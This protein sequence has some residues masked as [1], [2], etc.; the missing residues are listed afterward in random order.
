MKI[1]FIALTSLLLFT[2]I[3]MKAQFIELPDILQETQDQHEERMRWWNDAKFGMF[4]HWGVYA[5]PGKGEWIMWMDQIPV[6]EY[7]KLAD[8][9]NPDPD[10]MEQWAAVAKEAGMKYMVLTTRHCDGFCLW[11]SKSSWQDFTIMNTPAKFDAVG[12]FVESARKQD[13]RVGFYYSVTDWRFP[14]YFLPGIYR[15]SAEQ[16]KKQGYEQA[17]E[18]LTEYG[19]I[20]IMWWDAGSDDYIALAYEVQGFEIVKRWTNFGGP[21]ERH[22]AGPPLWEGNKLNAMVRELQPNIIINNRIS[23]Q[24]IEWE[25][26]YYTPEGRVGKFDTRRDWET[27]EVLSTGWWGWEPDRSIK[28]LEHVITNLVSIVTGGGNYLLNVGPRPDGYIAPQYVE[29]LREVGRWLDKYGESIYGTRAGPHPNGE[30]GGF[31]Y[32][33]NVLYIHV[34]D[35][36]KLPESLPYITKKIKKVSCLTGGEV[37]YSQ[38]QKGLEISVEGEPDDVIDT[39]IKFELGV[40]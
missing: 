3:I 10:A 33:E 16:M 24:G 23:M 12:N 31:T 26:D 32:K 9:F 2:G 22:F 11:P 35:W 18:L 40:E 17:R 14:G 8:E 1:R 13:L 30:W 37:Q 27:C 38:S 28:S 34:L 15:N 20:D 7:A 21:P 36:S 29:R 25:G 5:I 4:L 39:I 19:D 6:E